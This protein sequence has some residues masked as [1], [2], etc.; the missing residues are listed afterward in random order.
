[1]LAVLHRVIRLVHADPVDRDQGAVDDDMVALAEAGEGFMKAGRPGSQDLQGLVDVPP[2]SGLGYPETGS[3]L[4]ERLVL[5]QMDQRD[6]RL[7]EAAEL[8]PAGVAGPVVLVQQPGN[9]LNQ[10]VRD[11]ERGRI[12]KPSGPLRSPV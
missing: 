4:R 2:G 1:M 9:M 3:E 12:R 5:P 11:V 8:T 7:L 10:L 6:Q